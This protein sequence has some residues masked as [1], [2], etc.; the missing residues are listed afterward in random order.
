MLK[1]IAGK[2]G[3]KVADLR[4]KSEGKIESISL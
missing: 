4:A 3:I 1:S 2:M